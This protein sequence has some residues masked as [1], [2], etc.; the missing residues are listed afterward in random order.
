MCRSSLP[1]AERSDI[2]TRV[3]GQDGGVAQHR[4]IAEVTLLD[5]HQPTGVTRHFYGWADGSRTPV[6]RPVS[7]QL[8]CYPG[9]EPRVYLFY[10]DAE[11]DE[12]TDTLHDSLDEALAQAQAEFGVQPNEW[13]YR[14]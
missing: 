8:A 6:P 10:C 2:L 5:R 11:G 3:V 9:D 1:P 12:M 4:V 14:A 7:L 13:A